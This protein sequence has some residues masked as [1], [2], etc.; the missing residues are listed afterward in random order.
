MFNDVHPSLE[1][2]PAYFYCP[3]NPL[4][5]VCLAHSIQKFLGQV[6]NPGHSSDNARSLTCWA[7]RELPP[8][9]ILR[10]IIKHGLCPQESGNCSFWFPSHTMHSHAS[11]SLPML[12]PLCWNA[13]PQHSCLWTPYSFFK[14]HHFWE[15]FPDWYPP[16]WPGLPHPPV[17]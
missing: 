3:K 5:S 6:L 13:L 7:T 4:C 2:H 16:S 17:A 11:V 14:T 15:L 10:L 1:Y 8:W 12:F 9:H